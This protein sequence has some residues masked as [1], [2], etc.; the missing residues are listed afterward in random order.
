MLTTLLTPTEGSMK[1]CD[2]IVG[3]DDDFIRE[4]I[5]I[6]YQQ[7]CLDDVLSV[8]ENLICRGVI[9]GE[10]MKDAKQI[11]EKLKDKYRGK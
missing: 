5:G 6:V 7:N 1:V 2:N 10:S 11:N 3:L 4:K 8:E 9:H